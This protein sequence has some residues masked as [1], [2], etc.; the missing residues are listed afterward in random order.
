M[1]RARER[2]EAITA[3][4]DGQQARDGEGVGV[5]RRMY[6]L[7]R[8]C[9]VRAGACVCV[10]VGLGGVAACGGSRQAFVYLEHWQWLQVELAT[11]TPARRITFSG[12]AH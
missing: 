8:T 4:W 12:T 11:P 5:E 6:L 10:G 9:Y 7:H 3:T 2:A 1:L